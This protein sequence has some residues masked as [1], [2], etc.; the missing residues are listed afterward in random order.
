MLVFHDELELI[1]GQRKS[2][3]G[4]WMAGHNGLR[5]IATQMGTPDF[6]RVRI[7]IGRPSHPSQS[8]ADFVLSAPSQVEKDDI[9]DQFPAIE[10]FVRQRIVT[11][12]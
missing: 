9:Y 6:V 12:S 4:W 11:I 1:P 8:V 2:K 10:A 3:N 7:G 5:S